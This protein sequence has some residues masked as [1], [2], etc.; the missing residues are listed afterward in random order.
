[1][2]AT[3]TEA[4]R[5]ILLMFHGLSDYLEDHPSDEYVAEHLHA[6]FGGFGGNDDGHAL[7]YVL[8]L[9]KHTE[10]FPLLKRQGRERDSLDS[11]MPTAQVYG[12]MV[13]AWA[14]RKRPGRLTTERAHALLH[15]HA[16]ER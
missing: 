12:P 9:T 7:G 2:P 3:E 1:V 10:D 5:E 14:A 8:F 16:G 13:A 6:R 15:A 4:F 11:H